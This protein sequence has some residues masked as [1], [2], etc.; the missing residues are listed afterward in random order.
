M[1][2]NEYYAEI[3]GE[4]HSEYQFIKNISKRIF[5]CFLLR[6]IERDGYLI[7]HLTSK[8][9]LRLSNEY[10][11]L[12]K[13]KLVENETV[14][15]LGLAQW[16][17]DVWQNQGGCMVNTIEEMKGEDA[18]KHL[19]D[20]E[21]LKK[22]FTHNLEKA[23][24]EITK[25]KCIVYFRGKQEYLE[26]H[27]KVMRKHT[28]MKNPKI[29]DKEL[30]EIFVNFI[31]NSLKSMPIENNEPLGVFFN[32]NSGIEIYREEIISCMP[33]KNNPYYTNQIYDLCDLLTIETFSKEFVNYII[34][35][36][37]INL[38]FSDY[39]NPDTFNIIMDNLD[40]LLR[41]YRRSLYFS[42]PE[43]T[44]NN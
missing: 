27:L 7:E 2:A 4:E 19:F 18:S 11:S 6:K 10:T 38:R 21:N 9:Q 36:K 40:F 28:K 17:N 29:T 5:G 41:F 31:E 20:D 24:I 32:P 39:E 16:K 22:E 44:I 8:K 42:K 34:D 26:F 25:G 3:L 1:R 23:F 35:N 12:E 14:L 43:V 15:S 33:D 37:L 13:V 30:D